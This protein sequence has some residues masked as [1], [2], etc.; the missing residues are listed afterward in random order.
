MQFMLVISF[1]LVMIA[2]ISSG[3]KRNAERV[4]LDA[5]TVARQMGALHRAASDACAANA[6]GGSGVIEHADIEPF[7]PSPLQGNAIKHKRFILSHWD[8]TARLVVT[9]LDPELNEYFEEGKSSTVSYGSVSSAMRDQGI[10]G[11]SSYAGVWG[12]GRVNTIR[13]QSMSGASITLPYVLT[14]PFVGYA[15]PVGTP[16]LVSK[17]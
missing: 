8:A 16:I 14:S 2:G 15:I 12:N 5:G 11:H 10:T 6:C 17:L 4:D 3:A 9:W 1:I 7:L 13:H